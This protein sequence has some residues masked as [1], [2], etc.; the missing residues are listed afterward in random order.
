MNQTMRFKID[1]GCFEPIRAHATDAGLDIRSPIDVTVRA[2]GSAVINS[3]VHAEIVSYDDGIGSAGLILP[4]SGLNI[5]NDCLSFGVV[6]EGYS[7]A[8]VVKIYNLGD[9]DFH[10]HRGDKITQLLIADVRYVVPEIVS[11]I[12]SGDRGDNGFGSTGK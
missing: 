7:G 4:K 8:I 10:V 1:E 2:H 6:D 12:E 3:G 11:E 5:K 9:E